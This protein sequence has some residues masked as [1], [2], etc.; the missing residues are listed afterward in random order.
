MVWSIDG[1]IARRA[2]SY[3]SILVQTQ[4]V[5]QLQIAMAGICAGLEW[6]MVIC[7]GEYTKTPLIFRMG[8]SRDWLAPP[9][10]TLIVQVCACRT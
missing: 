3:P 10:C 7:A 6:W 1:S 4:G 9:S 2:S 5:G 8:A